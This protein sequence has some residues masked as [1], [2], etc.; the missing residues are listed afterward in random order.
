MLELISNFELK[1][2]N[3]S[4]KLSLAVLPASTS[5]FGRDLLRQSQ[6]EIFRR[7]GWAAVSPLG[8]FDPPPTEGVATACW[9][10]V[11][12]LGSYL[13]SPDPKGPV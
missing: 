10:Y 11:L 9:I 7:S 8:G 13:Q 5:K 12:Q 3:S 1:L 2:R 4:L 6:A